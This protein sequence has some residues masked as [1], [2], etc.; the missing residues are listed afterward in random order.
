VPRDGRERPSD[1]GAGFIGSHLTEALLERGAHVVVLDDLS[2]GRASNLDAALQHPACE[3][4]V[5][6]A[7]DTALVDRLVR[8]AGAVLHLAAAVGVKLVLERRLDSLK[9][10]LPGQGRGRPSRRE[11]RSPTAPRV[12]ASGRAVVTCP[13]TSRKPLPNQVGS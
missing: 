3:L 9:T 12:E 10:K 6:S 4:V 5:G 13:T 11:P 2:T 1:R 7:L 8:D